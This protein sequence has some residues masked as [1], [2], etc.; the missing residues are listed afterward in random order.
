MRY[1][2]AVFLLPHREAAWKIIQERLDL[3]EEAFA[4]LAGE[5]GLGALDQPANR[6]HSIADEVRQQVASVNQ[7]ER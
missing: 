6:L 3:L 7:G 4:S 1:R 5:A 2:P